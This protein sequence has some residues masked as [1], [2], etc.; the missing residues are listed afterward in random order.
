MGEKEP[1]WPEGMDAEER[2]RHVALT[3]TR[4]R[5][6]GWIAKE[7]DV[8][9]DTAVK[10]L[11]RMA[12]RGELAVVETNDG[13]GYKPDP[14]TQLL[15]EVRR[16]AENA[17]EGELM[18]ELDA[19][20]DEIASWKE[21]Y[22]VDSLTEL[23]QSLGDEELSAAERQERMRIAEDWTANEETREAIQF[24]LELKDTITA[25][26]GNPDPADPERDALPQEG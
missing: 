19:I 6:A 20:S 9:R 8:S 15:D 17:T 26:V 14:V 21:T 23:R 24:A 13:T 4:P 5:N 1:M 7:A 2:V 22:G 16:L 11:K 3:R 18:A 25:I 12:D 10:Y